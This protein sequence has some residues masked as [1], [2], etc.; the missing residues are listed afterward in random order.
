MNVCSC[1]GSILID[2]GKKNRLLLRKMSVLFFD[3]DNTL[4]SHRTHRIPQSAMNALRIAKERG[5]LLFLCSGRSVQ[6][7]ADY[8]DHG[9]FDGLIA[10]S[11]AT[12]ILHGEMVFSHII[13]DEIAEEVISLSEE[14][15]FGLFIHCLKRSLMN[16]FGCERLSVIFQ[17]NE[18]KL[19]ET[20]F[21]MMRSFPKEPIQKIDIFYR[22]D[23]LVNEIRKRF[24][25]VLDDCAHLDP[26]RIDFGS[27][28]TIAGVSKGSAVLEMMRILGKKTKDSFGFG[29]SEND[30]EM[31]KQCGTGIAMGNADPLT[32]AAADYV[33]T[34]I[35]EDGILNAMKYFEL[36]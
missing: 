3:I 13:P 14:Y 31:L 36:I 34:D 8:Y 17:R 6:G 16:P 15:D 20:G 30:I 9:L 26:E 2:K 18:A 28:L 33:T 25:K 27:E 32:K 7:L 4:Y 21:S 11:G 5:H 12:G 10:S 29:D 35:D 22:K 19:E 23:S 24:P 1:T